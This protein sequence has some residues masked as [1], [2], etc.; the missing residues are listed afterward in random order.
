MEKGLFYDP[1]SKGAILHEGPS[2]NRRTILAIS[3][4]CCNL[5][6]YTTNVLSQSITRAGVQAIFEL[7]FASVSKQVLAGTT[8]QMKISLICI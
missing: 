1:A 2:E 8:I 3:H 7:P 4:E 6:G 5:I